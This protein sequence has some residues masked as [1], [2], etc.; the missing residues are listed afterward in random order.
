MRPRRVKFGRLRLTLSQVMKLV[1]FAAVACSSVMEVVHLNDLGT[2]GGSAVLILWV[3][4][5]IPLVWAVVALPLLR[6]GAFKDWLIRALLS[7]PVGVI[8]AFAVGFLVWSLYTVVTQSSLV[9]YV[10][11]AATAGVT[12][13]LGLSLATLVRWI[14][15]GWCP[16]CRLPL[17]ILDVLPFGA[18]AVTPERPYSCINCNGR[19][20]K[21][22]GKWQSETVD[23]TSQP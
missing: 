13:V 6:T 22:E 2:L 10:E 16:E 17:L 11:V 5:A 12:L 7:I 9:S 4:V 20:L 18:S 19:Y 1:V 3:V 14:I 8:L 15:P 21:R 23:V